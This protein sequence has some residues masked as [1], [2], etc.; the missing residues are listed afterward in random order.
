[1]N[2]L[3]TKFKEEKVAKYKGGL[4]HKTQINLAYNSNR[5]EGSKLSEE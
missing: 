5:I 4:Y 1:M 2:D 3:L